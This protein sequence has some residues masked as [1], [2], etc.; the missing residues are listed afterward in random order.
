MMY[1]FPL[2]RTSAGN[3]VDSNPEIIIYGFVAS[4]F[5]KRDAEAIADPLLVNTLVRIRDAVLVRPKCLS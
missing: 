5:R 3:S 4:D 1:C 2:V